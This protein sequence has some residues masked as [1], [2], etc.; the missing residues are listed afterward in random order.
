MALQIRRRLCES[1][2]KCGNRSSWNTLSFIITRCNNSLHFSVQATLS[3]SPKFEKEQKPVVSSVTTESEKQQEKGQ[4]QKEPVNASKEKQKT[5][6]DAA[7]QNDLEVG[8]KLQKLSDF[9]TVFF[10]PHPLI[11]TGTR[12]VKSI[13]VGDGNIQ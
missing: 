9:T 8:A 6:R 10:G 3:L 11:T 2:Q 7:T 12:S 1:L 13:Q 5:R 4:E